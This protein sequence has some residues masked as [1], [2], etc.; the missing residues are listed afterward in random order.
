MKMI[1]IGVT[2]PS[3]ENKKA[4]QRLNGMQRKSAVFFR[5]QL[6]SWC[7][8]HFLVEISGIEPLTS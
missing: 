3:V 1:P 8:V 4:I 7:S 5:K 2:A 6:I